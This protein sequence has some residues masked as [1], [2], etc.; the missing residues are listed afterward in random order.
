MNKY[1]PPKS[2]QHIFFRIWFAFGGWW[3]SVA[4]AAEQWQR[5]TAE[6][7]AAFAEI[8]SDQWH[9]VRCEWYEYGN[10]IT[11]TS[12]TN[13]SHHHEH[14]FEHQSNVQNFDRTTTRDMDES[15]KRAAFLRF[16]ALNIILFIVTLW[17]KYRNKCCRM[18]LNV[19]TNHFRYIS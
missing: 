4:V 18:V 9:T 3:L 15:A 17:A 12:T 1:V 13:H 5:I 19:Q 16:S 6:V 11:T 10:T 2:F 14:V 7:A 8:F